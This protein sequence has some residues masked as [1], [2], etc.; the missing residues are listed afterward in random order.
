MIHTKSKMLSANIYIEVLF[1]QI[2]PPGM[3]F[4]HPGLGLHGKAQGT[5]QR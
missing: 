1:K 3:F 5:E 2:M 4:D